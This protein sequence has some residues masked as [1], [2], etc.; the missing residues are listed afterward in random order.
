MAKYAGSLPKRALSTGGRARN[1]GFAFKTGFLNT[2]AT[3]REFLT[4]LGWIFQTAGI[5][6]FLASKP[7]D[8]LMPGAIPGK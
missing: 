5:C 7:S 6:Q 8:P 3:I 1:S 4:L 2:Y